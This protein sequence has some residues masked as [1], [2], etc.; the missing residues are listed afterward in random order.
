MPKQLKYT[1]TLPKYMANL[2]NIKRANSTQ[3]EWLYEHGCGHRHR[4]TKHFSCFLKQYEIEEVKGAMD[5]EAGALDADFDICLSWCIKTINKDEIFYDHIT[6]SDLDKGIYD[7]RIIETLVD[8]MWKYDRLVLHY[9]K[10]RWFDLPFIR[11]RYLWLKAR[12]LYE[13]AVFPSYGEMYVSDTFGM[14]KSLLK[15][16]SR[17]QNSIANVVQGEDIKTKIDK[18]YW[19]GIKY[20][21]NKVREAAISYIVDHNIKDCYQLEGNYLALLP[22]VNETRTSI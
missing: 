14:A 15:I 17:R 21:N 7:K 20:G 3:Y 10:N 9:G 19:M 1:D 12:N 5:I 4:F 6:K 2:T 8:T 11:A 16:S 18:D 13:G 22:F